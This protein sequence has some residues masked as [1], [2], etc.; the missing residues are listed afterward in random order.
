[1]DAEG[2]VVTE[3]R[4]A[5]IEKRLNDGEDYSDDI[6]S[7]DYAIFARDSAL[8]LIAEVRRLR[9][10]VDPSLAVDELGPT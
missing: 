3:E 4:L 8:A 10:S 2:A 7:P 1:V 5:A 6:Y 9:E